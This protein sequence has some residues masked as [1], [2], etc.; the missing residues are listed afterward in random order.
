MNATMRASGRAWKLGD[1]VNIDEICATRYITKGRGVW[2]DHTFESLIPGFRERARPGD[3]VVAGEGF[4]YGMGHDHPILGMQDCGIA[5]VVAK[6]FGP[7]FYRACIA[8]GMP[9]L[10]TTDDLEDVQDG[11]AVEADFATGRLVVGEPGRVVQC[12]ALEGT[13]LEI[14]QAGN[15]AAFLRREL[16]SA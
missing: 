13:A 12:V 16:Q 15:L 14:V 4:A 11:T 7:Q 2:A 3:V 10:E 8:H 1:L 9:L 5:G 6:S